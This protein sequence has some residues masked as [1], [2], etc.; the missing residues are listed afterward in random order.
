ML[1][2]SAEHLEA[3]LEDTELLDIFGDAAEVLSRAE[4]ARPLARALAWGRFTALLKLT[5]KSA[6]S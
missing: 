1:G 5:A 2:T 6:A 3:P 4:V